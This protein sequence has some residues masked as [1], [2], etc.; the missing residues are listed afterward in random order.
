MKPSTM[1][2]YQLFEGSRRYQV[3][4]YQRPYVWVRDA[5]WAPLWEDVRDRAEA[6][7]RRDAGVTAN[8]VV[9]PHFLGAMVVRDIPVFGLHVR[10]FE[11]IDGQ[12][13]L[14]TLQLLLAACR[15][16]L[17]RMPDVGLDQEFVRLTRNEGSVADEDIERLKVWP[18]N[19]DREAFRAVVTAASVQDVEDFQ[20][21]LRDEWRGSSRLADAYMFFY[22]A[23]HEWLN[24]SDAERPSPGPNARQRAV[25][26][27]EAFRYHLQVV[28]IALED[29]DDPQA[30]FETLNARGQPLLP[31]DLVR[32]FV[33]TQANANGEDADRLYEKYWRALD[34][35][36]AEAF[37]REQ[38]QFGRERRERI[39]LFLYHFLTSRLGEDFGVVHLFDTFKRWWRSADGPSTV[40]DGLAMLTRYAKAYERIT[41]P[42]GLTRFDTFLRRLEAFE[43]TPLHPVLLH[44]LVERDLEPPQLDR[45]GMY[46]ESF[47]V[48]RLIVG[49]TGKNLNRISLALLL[50]LKGAEQVDA[51]TVAGSLAE[52]T[53]DSVRWPDDREFERAWLNKPVYRRIRRAS[54]N[55]VL[56]GLDQQLTTGYQEKIHIEGTTT[57]EHV[58]PRSWDAHWPEPRL[59]GD[60]GDETP[61]EWRN[62]LLHT[63]GNLTLLTS[64]LNT[65]VSNATYARKRPEITKQSALRM[66]S[67]FQ[68]VEA[69]DEQAI[70]ARGALLFATAC[71]I[72]P[73]PEAVHGRAGDGSLRENAPWVENDSRRDFDE[74]IV[75]FD[76]PSLHQQVADEVDN[77]E[78]E[79]VRGVRATDSYTQVHLRRWP[80]SLHYEFDT[81]RDATE[82]AICIDVEM[83]RSQPGRSEVVKLLP[84]LLPEIQEAFP[85]RDVIWD[86]QSRVTRRLKV[87]LDPSDLGP[88]RV[89]DGLERLIATT[90]GQVD[91]V[92]QKARRAR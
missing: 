39:V 25:A 66:N 61:A 53:G 32:N 68:D 36:E 81:G 77:R 18:T 90:V 14:T 16:V 48:R 78:L 55:T 76:F 91:D 65:K 67:Y 41:D 26:L 82:T 86:E 30:I 15:D 35:V 45:I 47:L 79:G 24:D 59:N 42:T 60:G 69:W 9:R 80:K 40:E 52:G 71:E 1:T 75:G 50:R 33:F 31:S 2:I 49:L 74:P 84:T 46:I 87:M 20:A 89:V 7:L 88:D 4:L 64:R 63:F 34:D 62:R 6:A 72:W 92:M 38:V 3:P 17:K 28:E 37:W 5:Q 27:L 73:T 70:L 22:R 19:A 11:V 56:R 10:S 8:G 23:V 57:I 85:G 12:Q 58:L 43:V 29:S 54:L 13:R 21:R 51:E 44:L 83:K